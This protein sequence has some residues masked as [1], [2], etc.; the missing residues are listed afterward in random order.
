MCQGKNPL[1]IEVKFLAPPETA[2]RP[3][4][5]AIGAVSQ[6]RVFE[7][8]AVFDDSR[9]SL[10]GRGQLLRLRRDQ[11][12][13]LTF[14]SPVAGAD[15]GFKIREETELEIG[16]IEA[17]A[18]ILK[19]LGFDRIFVY[20]KWRETFVVDKAHICLDTMP[21][22]AF[23]EIEA[24]KEAIGRL[25]AALGLAWQERIVLNYHQVFAI[26]RDRLH[27]SF[28]DI[29]FANFAGIAVDLPALLPLLRV[30]E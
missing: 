17:M 24:D 10:A 22:G 7:S 13:R 21:F 8:N 20:E 27:L 4:L 5:E 6:G 30:A 9:G 12:C 28:T 16:D 29:S 3:R 2:L 11:G 1:E 14:K 26:V 19:A 15:R 18:K 25:A 23:V